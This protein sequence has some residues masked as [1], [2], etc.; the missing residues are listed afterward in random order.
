MN[1]NPMVLSLPGALRKITHTVA[2]SLS[3]TCNEQGQPRVGYCYASTKRTITPPMYVSPPP[4]SPRILWQVN[5]LGAYVAPPDQAQQTVTAAIHML[6][7]YTTNPDWDMSQVQAAAPRRASS[8][9]P[10]AKSPVRRSEAAATATPSTAPPTITGST[11]A[12]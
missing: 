9:A 2:G 1:Y 10:P 6:A 7:S 12:A 3:F 5:V 11:T 4:Q 8:A